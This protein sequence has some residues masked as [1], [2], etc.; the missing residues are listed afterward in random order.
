MLIKSI[1]YP[2]TCIQYD[3]GSV[4]VCVCGVWYVCVCGMYMVY[5]CGVCGCCVYI[6]YVWDT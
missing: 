3:C 4:C 6:M 5:V 1:S 2:G